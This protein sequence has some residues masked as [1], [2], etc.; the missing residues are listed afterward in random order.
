MTSPDSHHLR[1]AIGW[2]ELGNW[3]EANEE[4]E[5][6]T[7]ALRAHP[8]VLEARYEI[9]AAAKRWEE[10]LD[11]A[12]AIVK[13][14]PRKSFGWIRRSFALHE[15]KRTQDAFEKLSPVAE[16]FS[17]EWVIPY[18]LACYCAQLG[19]QDEAR[20][21]FKKA[22][23]IEEDEVRRVGIDDPD[24][25]PLWDSMSGSVWKKEG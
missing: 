15:L 20:E 25:Q 6:I 4:L 14:V 9:Y 21:W 7:P 18:N 3:R 2:L 5:K 1:A 13:L 23:A 19:R 10:C 12:E 16:R 11:I 22:M 24:L 17:K 8:N